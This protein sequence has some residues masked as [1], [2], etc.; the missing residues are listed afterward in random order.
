MASSTRAKSAKCCVLGLLGASRLN[1]ARA[2][3][4]RIEKVNSP[5]LSDPPLFADD[6][7]PGRRGNGQ[8]RAEGQWITTTS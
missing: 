2:V 6:Q 5:L 8:S 4:I 1:S 3:R 7:S